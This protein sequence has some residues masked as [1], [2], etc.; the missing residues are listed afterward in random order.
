MEKKTFSYIKDVVI[1]KK[2]IGSVNSNEI[3]N[4][5]TITFSFADKYTSLNDVIKFIRE[6][7]NVCDIKS[8][9][10]L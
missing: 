1:D 10:D 6:V 7:Q 9:S 8:L 3:I 5:V 4:S 2:N